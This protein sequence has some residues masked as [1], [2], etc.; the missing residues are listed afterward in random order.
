M[1]D[2]L[3]ITW[4]VNPVFARIGGLEIMWYGLC[5]MAALV[6]GALFFINFCKR[7]R[8]S[9]LYADRI[10]W[11]GV[12][13]TVIGARLGHCFFYEPA[14]YWAHPLEIFNI[15]QG[16]LASHGAAVGLL[17]GLWGFSKDADGW[18]FA[19]VKP[20]FKLKLTVRPRM[21]LP[22]IWAIDRVMLPVT[23]GGAVVR[24]GNLINSEI[25]GRATDLPWGFV[26]VRAGETVPMHPTQI[27]EALCYVVTFVVLWFLYYKKDFGRKRPGMLFGVG[28]I[29]VFLTRFFIEFIKNPQIA[30]EQSM[31]LNIGQML[32]IPFVL[33]GILL[34][35][36][37]K[38][39]N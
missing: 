37:T 33:A 39:K 10:F 30:A 11:W 1:T 3:A 15:R 38:T 24:L 13:A 18:F 22:Y 36:R 26:F 27:Y 19:K 20:L 7:E 28:L 35:L 6:G 25:Y 12:L 16:G 5:W 32:S 21:K 31:V 23:I 4:D 14:Y 9:Q 29:G 34:V 8:L 17:L 2:F